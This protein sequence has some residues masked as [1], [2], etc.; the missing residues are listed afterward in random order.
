MLSALEFWWG[1][2][3]WLVPYAERCQLILLGVYR[4]ATGRLVCVW[5]PHHNDKNNNS[6]DYDDDNNS[7][8]NKQ[9]TTT[10]N[11]NNSNINNN[12]SNNKKHMSFMTQGSI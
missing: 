8:N 7:N 1:P 6:D 11:N 10:N 12:N 4:R 3:E 9:Q 5:A 2:L